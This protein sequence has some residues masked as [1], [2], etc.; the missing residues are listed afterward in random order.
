MKQYQGIKTKTKPFIPDVDVIVDNF[1]RLLIGSKPVQLTYKRW[2]LLLAVNI[3]TCKKSLPSSKKT[4]DHNIS[5]T[6]L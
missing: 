1:I 2:H 6:K 4:Q 5:N 3:M